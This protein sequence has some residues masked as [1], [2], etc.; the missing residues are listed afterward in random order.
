MS[1]HGDPHELV[2][3]HE[4][5]DV[6]F[7][8]TVGDDQEDLVLAQVG[9]MRREPQRRTVY[10]FDTHELMLYDAGVILRARI[11]R[12]DDDD[13]TVKLR[14]VKPAEIYRRVKQTKGFKIELD[15][16]GDTPVCSAKLEATPRRGEVEDVAAER[17]SLRTLFSD[18]QERLI[19]DYAPIGISWAELSVLGPVEVRKWQIPPTGFAHEITVEQWTLP[20]GDDLIEMSIKVPAAQALGAGDAFHAY[21]ADHGIDRHRDQHAK[22]RTVLEYFAAIMRARRGET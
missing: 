8:I 19:A 20:N 1:T 3:D 17:R 9:E 22:A 5:E 15:V 10:F 7:K 21:L 18:D 13:S 16:V 6:E 14:P 11:T 4:V 2:F 12:G